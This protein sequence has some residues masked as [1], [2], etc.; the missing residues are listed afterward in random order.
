MGAYY[1]SFSIF[2]IRLKNSAQTGLASIFYHLK[3]F[4]VEK[5]LNFSLVDR[6]LD[7]E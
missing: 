3:D 6:F 4:P 2:I 1:D 7:A 5:G